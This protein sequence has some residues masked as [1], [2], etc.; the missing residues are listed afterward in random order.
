[1]ITSEMTV[2]SRWWW[3]PGW[4]PGRSFYDWQVTPTQPVADKLVEI[5]APVLTRSRGFEQVDGAR[6]RVSVQGIGFVDGVKGVDLAA[7]VAG[8]RDLLAA[9]A[10]FPLTFGPPVVAADS[11]RLPIALPEELLRV[12]EDLISALTGVWIRERIPEFGEPLHP[13]LT[14]A[15]ATEPTPV[16]AIEAALAADGFADFSLDDT[17]S[18]VSL[19]E[20]LCENSRYDLC[21][22]SAAELLRAPDPVVERVGYDGPVFGMSTRPVGADLL[23]G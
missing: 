14:L 10:P 8:A 4:T 18:E 15:H 5:F 11:V 1:M 19:V 23:A 7:L 12:R 6:L 2:A 3:R 22:V 16:R 13:Y 21:E 17:V 9:H 20:L